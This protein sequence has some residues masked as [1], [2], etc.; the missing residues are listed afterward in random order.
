[1]KKKSK[2]III[3]KAEGSSV[4]IFYIILK[5]KIQ[6]NANFLKLIR[7]YTVKSLSL[8]TILSRQTRGHNR[9]AFNY[10]NFERG[11]KTERR[12][13]C[14]KKQESDSQ[15]IGASIKIPTKNLYI[16][17]ICLIT[18]KCKPDVLKA[19]ETRKYTN[20]SL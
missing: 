8:I 17:R 7:F 15:P 18:I 12:Y 2:Y 6:V 11:L 14:K 16:A 3:K 5:Q 1:M 19:R 20:Y 13:G 4:E 9:S 10:S